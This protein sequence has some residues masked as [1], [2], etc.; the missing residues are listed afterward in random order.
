MLKKKKKRG[1]NVGQAGEVA[2]D[3]E[4]GDHDG[5]WE[6]KML[7]LGARVKHIHWMWQ[8]PR[9]DWDSPEG[10]EAWM[11]SCGQQQPQ[12]RRLPPPALQG[13]QQPGAKLCH[14]ADKHACPEQGW[15]PGARA[16]PRHCGVLPAPSCSPWHPS[17][18]P[19]QTPGF[20]SPL[21]ISPFL[22]Y[23]HFYPSGFSNWWELFVQK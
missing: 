13:Q 3:K 15:G 8:Q 16:N 5:L 23:V 18:S 10:R 12:R 1:E 21:P 22:S 11:Q 4:R 20:A 14:A 9:R 2:T 6:E 7:D 17:P 19:A